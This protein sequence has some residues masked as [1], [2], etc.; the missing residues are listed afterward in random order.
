MYVHLFRK[1]INKNIIQHPAFW[2]ISTKQLK[3][4]FTD[5]PKDI[6]LKMIL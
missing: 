5:V 2:R 6:S 4:A 3:G 1:Q